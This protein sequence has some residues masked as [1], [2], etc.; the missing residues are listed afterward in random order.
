MTFISTPYVLMQTPIRVLQSA[1][2]IQQF[3][4]CSH[5]LS[6]TNSLS[7]PGGGRVVPL[8]GICDT[9]TLSLARPEA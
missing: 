6:V 1:V 9:E 7:H 4:A 2:E 5:H 3:I 8:A